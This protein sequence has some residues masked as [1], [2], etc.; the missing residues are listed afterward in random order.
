MNEG[1]HTTTTKPRLPGMS[2]V[3]VE[4]AEPAALETMVPQCVAAGPLWSEAQYLESGF[5][6]NWSLFLSV[7]WLPK[8]GDL[9]SIQINS[10]FM[11]LFPPPSVLLPAQNS[12]STTGQC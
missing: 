11:G 8:S 10:F 4:G 3:F 6:P 7:L 1:A 2:L 12:H 9:L 5:Q